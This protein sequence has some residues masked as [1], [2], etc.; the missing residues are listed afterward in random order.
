[1]STSGA[2]VAISSVALAQASAAK[3]EACKATV[4]TYKP[5]TATVAEMRGYAE[6]VQRLHPT[7]RTGDELI[8]VK[9]VIVLVLLGAVVGAWKSYKNTVYFDWF[10]IGTGFVGGAL[11]VAAILLVGGWVLA[12]VGFLFT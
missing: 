11:T 8:A 10:W 9:V 6:C 5:E 4:K 2:S 7:E 1:M 12:G 3:T